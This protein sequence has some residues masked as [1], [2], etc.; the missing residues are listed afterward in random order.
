MPFVSICQ[1]RVIISCNILFSPPS[2]LSGSLQDVSVV[3]KNKPTQCSCD[4]LWVLTPLL[5]RDALSVEYLC[6]LWVLPPLSGTEAQPI[7]A[8]FAGTHVLLLLKHRSIE[9][10]L[11]N[12]SN[13]K[14]CQGECFSLFCNCYFTIK[15]FLMS[16]DLTAFSKTDLSISFPVSPSLGWNANPSDT[17]S[18][19]QFSVLSHDGSLSLVQWYFSD[20]LSLWQFCM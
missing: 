19:L 4:V 14:D 13:S 18:C 5:N 12:F 15:W 11:Q 1:F 8:T 3:F 9:G 17:G 2:N 10:L 16:S 7:T 6:F 20:S